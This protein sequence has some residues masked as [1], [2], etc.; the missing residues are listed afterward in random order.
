MCCEFAKNSQK[1]IGKWDAE[2]GYS[3][4]ILFW[5]L[6]NSVAKGKQNVNN[7][8]HLCRFVFSTICNHIIKTV[9]KAVYN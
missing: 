7:T 3:N 8:V 9:K 5:V 1:T 4:C 6:H 2:I